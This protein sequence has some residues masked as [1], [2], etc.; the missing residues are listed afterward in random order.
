LQR[1][2]VDA[3]AFGGFFQWEPFFFGALPFRESALR[4]EL[5]ANVPSL[6]RKKYSRPKNGP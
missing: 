1:S 6:S 2:D 4:F 5:L 3:E